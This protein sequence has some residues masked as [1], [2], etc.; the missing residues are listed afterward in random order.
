M[1]TCILYVLR[2]TVFYDFTTLCYTVELYLIGFSHK[3]RNN[4]RIFLRNFRCCCKETLKLFVVMTYVHGCARQ[5]VRRTNKHWITYLINEFAYIIHRCESAPLRLV[6][7][8]L[9][10]HRRELTTILSTVDAYRRCSEDRHCL[11]MKLHSE[12]VRNLTA[13]GNDDTTWIFEVYY[14]ENTLE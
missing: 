6:D 10:K 4:N 7:A 8:E 9:V 3:L 5:Y 2:D 11:T 13:N 14:V 1:N 12:V